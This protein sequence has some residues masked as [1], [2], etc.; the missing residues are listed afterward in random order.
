MVR[1]ER[2]IEHRMKAARFRDLKTLE[3][4]QWSFNPSVEE[5][6]LP[7]LAVGH[8]IRKDRDVLL[9]E[10]PG[11]VDYLCPKS[12][13]ALLGQRQ[14]TAN[15]EELAVCDQTTSCR[16]DLG[17]LSAT[18]TAPKRSP[19]LGSLTAPGRVQNQCSH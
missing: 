14:Q 3:D 8:F 9:L 5:K 10:P 6:P 19:R 11:P 13:I 18:V 16:Q 17:C 4:F 1:K 2:L 12:V 7:D 15:F